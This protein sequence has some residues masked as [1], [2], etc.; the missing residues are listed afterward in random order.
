MSG[1]NGYLVD[2]MIWLFTSMSVVCLLASLLPLVTRPHGMFRVFDFP[3]VQIV[4][5]A[6]ALLVIG[7]VALPLAPITVTAMAGL[8]LSI[9]I[10]SIYVA[11]FTRLWPR[12]SKS[13]RKG[14]DAFATVKI[15]VSN[16]KQSNREFDRVLRLVETTAPDIA[17]FMETDETWAS[18]LQPVFDQF[19]H[20]LKCPLGNSYGMCLCSNFRLSAT[21][22]QFLLNPEV[23]SFNCIVELEQGNSFRLLTVHPEPPVATDDT[24]GR[25][26]EIALIGKLV[27][28]DPMPVIVTGDLNDVA[29]SSTTRRF[30]RISRLLD[31]REG[32]GQYNTFDARFFFLRWPLDHIFHS[33][34]F[35]LV[36]MRRQPFVGSDHFPMLYTLALVED[37]R[38][39]RPMDKAGKQDLE[40]ADELIAIE[41]VRDRR[42]AG[43][44]WEDD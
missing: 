21:H 9:L 27:R 22:I 10:Q 6:A 25:D 12:R 38:P 32:R 19:V 29:W 44:D 24:I 34:H 41:Q 28:D 13:Y 8:A 20:S 1:S 36:S 16:V 17:V 23:P 37:G 7:L 2:A 43:H 31:P 11:R 3:R 14:D 4:V 33:R 15:L 30:L 40:E 35:Q 39:H 26:A 42:P 18:A 5:A